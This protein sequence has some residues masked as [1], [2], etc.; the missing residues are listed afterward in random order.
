M[1]RKV[2]LAGV[3]M[4][5]CALSGGVSAA[6]FSGVDL[7]DKQLCMVA[8]QANSAATG[9]LWAPQFGGYINEAI[10]RGLTPEKCGL[11]FP[12]APTNEIGKTATSIKK[13]QSAPANE[14]DKLAAFPEDPMKV[15][16]GVDWHEMDAPRA[17]EA[18]EAA[19]EAYPDEGRF[20][21]QLALA[22]RKRKE[23]GK[24]IQS[25]LKAV[26]RG[27]AAAQVH[28]GGMYLSGRVV[29][30]DE[31]RAIKLWVMAA[32]Q[33]YPSV[34]GSLRD[35]YESIGSNLRDPSELLK[36]RRMWAEQGYTTAQNNL[37]QMYQ[38]GK[39]VT[40][41]Y[42]EAVKWYR[43]AAERGDINSQTNLGSM[44]QNGE[45]VT[46]DYGKA[47]EWYREAAGQG[48][49]EAQQRL[50]ALY[51]VVRNYKKAA[52]WYH[53]AAEQDH[54]LA[55]TSLGLMYALG[56]GVTPDNKEAVKWFSKAAEQG[57]QFAQ[58]NL[59]M[60]YR[61]GL[62]VVKDDRKAV[63]W[64]RKSAV[65]GVA[66]AQVYLGAMLRD[67]VGTVRDYDQ[68][69]FWFRKAASQKYSGAETIVLSLS[70]F[71]GTLKH[72]STGSPESQHEVGRS[73][74]KGT[75]VKKDYIEAS[76]WIAKAANQGHTASQYQ[77]GVMYSEG[78]GVIQ[79]HVEAL[80]WLLLSTAR[81]EGESDRKQQIAKM[82]SDQ[83]AKARLLAEAWK[84]NS[85][86]G[87][88]A[89]P[90]ANTGKSDKIRQAFDIFRKAHH[91]AVAVII[92]NKEYG[93]NIPKVLFAYNDADEVRQL[94]IR[95]LGYRAGNI[96]DLR[97]ATY[98]QLAGAFGNEK[99][100]EG[101]LFD[102]LK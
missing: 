22:L 16:E 68:A 5:S 79:N 21:F 58:G 15:G 59:G 98:N 57:E 19:V 46:K 17:I 90:P 86:S 89:E 30:K 20:W 4:L 74:L 11:Y 77:L 34:E 40:K 33:G 66:K 63:E 101:Q 100:H 70:K 51:S 2:G 45:G 55:Q 8:A 72:A 53:K 24:A 25:Y 92:G 87:T 54:A 67:G 43:K 6:E 82:T 31:G 69:L 47:I 7:K 13:G 38:R 32:E 18:C 62:G 95:R 93:K 76:Y 23:N 52:K 84:P 88:Q 91:D 96:I 41:D 49:V 102:W 9:F 97:D 26:Q 3:V 65:Q 60:R 48:Y 42:Q 73:Y 10:R 75:G 81:G 28:L 12:V 44:Y 85:K 94:L 64:L 39:G 36:W 99:T 50:G 80:K 14:C 83:I 78:R 61:S 35:L 71:I 37:G 29:P 27:Y 56:K 1:F